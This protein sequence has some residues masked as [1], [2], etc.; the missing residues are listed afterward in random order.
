MG[1]TVLPGLRF[2][3][4]TFNLKNETN[5][6]NAVLTNLSAQTV[7]VAKNSIVALA[8]SVDETNYDPS[9]SMFNT[10]TEQNWID[11]SRLNKILSDLTVEEQ[12]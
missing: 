10:L 9:G 2:N 12:N 7:I 4:K 8:E 11:A 3:P 1:V 6:L 5:K